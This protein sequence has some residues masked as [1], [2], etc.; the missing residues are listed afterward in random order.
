[1]NLTD[2]KE[3]IK[4]CSKEDRNEIVRMI[5]KM[6]SD[7][8]ANAKSQFSVGDKVTSDDPRWYYGPGTIVKINRKNII[9]DCGTSGRV[10]ASATLLKHY[11]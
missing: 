4:I 10:N 8:I 11:E 5:N 7:K 9:V 1:M 6:H 3:F 2:V